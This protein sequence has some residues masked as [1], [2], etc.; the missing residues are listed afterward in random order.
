ML[1]RFNLQT[2]GEDDIPDLAAA[3]QIPDVFRCPQGTICNGIEGLCLLLRRLAYPCRLSDLVPRFGRP[4]PELS[5]LFNQV[6][7]FVYERHGHRIIEWN[8]VLL[9]PAQLEIYAA[10]ITS[11]GTA[12]NHCFGFVDGTV[13]AICRPGKHQR[14]VYNGHKRHHAPKF[15]SVVTPN[16]MIANLYGPVGKC[17]YFKIIIK[18]Y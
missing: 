3:L 4:V 17:V 2:I 16:G 15:Q 13:R 10:A 6:L 14:L 8:D 12:L 9:R 5:L 18:R 11:R 7:A 1:Q